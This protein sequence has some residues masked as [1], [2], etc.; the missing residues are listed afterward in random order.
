[1]SELK[2]VT[3]E[4]LEE[5]RKRARRYLDGDGDHIEIN[6]FV[7]QLYQEADL[8]TPDMRICER[9]YTWACKCD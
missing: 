5:L 2:P 1:M 4:F 3:P 6:R 7:E 9:C 8:P